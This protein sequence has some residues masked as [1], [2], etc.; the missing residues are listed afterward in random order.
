MVDR[1]STGPAILAALGFAVLLSVLGCGAQADTLDVT[2][3]Y[4]PG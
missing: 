4:L 1:R 3:Y 2:Y